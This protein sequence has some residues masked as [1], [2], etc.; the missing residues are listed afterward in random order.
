MKKIKRLKDPFLQTTLIDSLGLTTLFGLLLYRG[1][2]WEHPFLSLILFIILSAF[3][4]LRIIFTSVSINLTGSLVTLRL[5]KF[6]T[7][8]DIKMTRIVYMRAFGR[9][10]LY[11]K[12]IQLLKNKR[13]KIKTTYA[14]VLNLVD[15]LWKEGYKG[16]A[17]I[18]VMDQM[19]GLSKEINKLSKSYRRF[20]EK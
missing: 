18:Y 4:L 17:L 5:I 11:L 13:D 14:K 20:G 15:I 10:K 2:L 6:N 3:C 19:V 7:T 8:V 12:R 1:T 16:D 9:R